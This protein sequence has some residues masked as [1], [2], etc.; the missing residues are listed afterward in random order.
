M[1][2]VYGYEWFSDWAYAFAKHIPFSKAFGYEII[3]KMFQK[4]VMRACSKTLMISSFK[5]LVI[6]L[7]ILNICPM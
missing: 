3:L 1:R 5:V 4:T 6:L 2:L 7:V